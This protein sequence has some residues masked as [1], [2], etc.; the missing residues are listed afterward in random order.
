[1]SQTIQ[2][3]KVIESFT[4]QDFAMSTRE[5][6]EIGRSKV[7]D[8]DYP[9][10][11]ENYRK[12]FE[13]KFIREYYMRNIG[14]ETFGLFKFYLENWLLINMPYYNKLYESE[15][16]KFDPLMNTQ[17]TTT[18]NKQDMRTVDEAIN[19][20]ENRIKAIQ[21]NTTKTEDNTLAINK[22][23]IDLDT[24][25]KERSKL[26]DEDG[27]S[28]TVG[29][30]TS[31]D[32]GSSTQKIVDDNFKRTIK[33]DAPQDRLALTANDGEGVVEVA[34]TID[35]DTINNEKT[36]TESSTNANVSHADG[37]ETTSKNINENEDESQ[38]VNRKSTNTDSE[39]ENK[40]QKLAT[41]ENET[42]N[43]TKD[44][45]RNTTSNFIEDYIENKVGKIGSQT[46]SKMLTEYRQS[47]MRIDKMIYEELADL[48]MLVY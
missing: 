12:E 9:L 41:S 21:L 29:D 35:E 34:T 45:D 18:S 46:Y 7:F 6:I 30:S 11:N 32:N 42:N 22:L 31:N 5:R 2:L 14:V 47:F 4:D 10:F 44:V 26:I 33:S 17:M 28:N 3:R 16:L 19:E 37:S 27:L 38:T 13:T 20:L 15:L 8:F 39:T 23:K 43:T 48:F 24:L 36:N 25:Q 1:M 40:D